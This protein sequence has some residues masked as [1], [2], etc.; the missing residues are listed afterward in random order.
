MKIAILLLT[1]V[2]QCIFGP[3][4]NKGQSGF[5]TQFGGA[6]DKHATE[7]ALCLGRK[8][9]HDDWGI[10][11]RWGRCG[12]I[13]GIRANGRTIFVPRIDSGPWL[14]VS[15]KCT[16]NHTVV[17]CRRHG[18][19][20]IGIPRNDLE[21]WFGGNIMDGTR[22]VLRALGIRG[23]GHVRIWLVKRGPRKR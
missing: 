6:N 21:H 1:M 11:T 5:T 19:V 7:P 17:H 14:A 18:K 10:A 16:E 3:P 9:R 23:M 22:R 12:D 13:Y 8:T 2:M 20:M 4:P 15:M